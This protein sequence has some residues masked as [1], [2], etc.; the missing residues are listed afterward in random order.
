MIIIDYSN[1][2]ATLESMNILT[3]LNYGSHIKLMARVNNS[4]I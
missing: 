3:G 4:N 1:T 2:T